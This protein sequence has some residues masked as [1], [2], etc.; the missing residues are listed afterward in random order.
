MGTG[1]QCPLSGSALARASSRVGCTCR[2]LGASTGAA[3]ALVG[4]GRGRAGGAPAITWVVGEYLSEEG[5]GE[6]E[7]EL[8]EGKSRREAAAGRIPPRPQEL[9]IRTFGG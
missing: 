6:E 5:V 8:G 4:P 2:V 7:S 9:M 3:Q 1:S